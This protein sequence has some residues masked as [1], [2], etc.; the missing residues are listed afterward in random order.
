MTFWYYHDISKYQ[1][2]LHL[3]TPRPSIH[4]MISIPIFCYYHDILILSWYIKTLLFEHWSDISKAFSSGNIK[5]SYPLI[6]NDISWDYHN[7]LQ[8]MYDKIFDISKMIVLTDI[9]IFCNIEP[10][11]PR[12]TLLVGD[13][14]WSIIYYP[15]WTARSNDLKLS[16]LRI[17]VVAAT[18][19][20]FHT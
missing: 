15:Y 13:H 7:I 17:R 1:T 8:E 4:S 19:F 16:F 12:S 9:V 5:I 18:D 11:S 20:D 14:I 2:P 10:H 6:K 3:S